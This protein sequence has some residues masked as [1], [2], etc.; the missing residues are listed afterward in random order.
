[1]PELRVNKSLLTILADLLF[2]KYLLY[3]TAYRVDFR[4]SVSC[5]KI[6]KL[7]WKPQVRFNKGIKETVQWYLA[8]L[9]WM[10]GKLNV[11]ESYWKNVY[12]EVRQSH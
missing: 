9:P 3:I 2:M 12:K 7:G 1:M 11:L 5:A 8:H 4:Y 6:H 10:E